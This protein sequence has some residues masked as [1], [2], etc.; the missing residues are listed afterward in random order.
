MADGRFLSKSVSQNDQLARVSLEAALL[1]TWCVPHLDVE[2][3]M[4]GQAQLIHGQVCPLRPEIT[5]GRI[6]G[7][8]RELVRH[9]LVIWYSVSGRDYLAFPGFKRQQKGLREDREKASTIPSPNGRGVQL[10]GVGDDPSQLSLVDKPPVIHSGNGPEASGAPPHEVE[11]EVEGEVEVQVEAEVHQRGAAAD[12][13]QL[14]RGKIQGAAREALEGYARSARHPEALTLAV[15]AETPDGIHAKAGQTYEVV[16]QALA[17]MRAAGREFTPQILRAF[18]R[19]LL[20]QPAPARGNGRT[21]T[22][23]E[24]MRAAAARLEREAV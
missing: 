21:L 17:D 19:K 22:D 6:P 11:V 15:L 5:V 20:E 23:A 18:C 13:W 2:G 16:G 4:T 24:K 10:L 8:L 9:E 12:A 14:L 7:L 3:R 1:F